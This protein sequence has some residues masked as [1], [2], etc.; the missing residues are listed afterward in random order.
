MRRVFPVLANQ[1]SSRPLFQTD[2]QSFLEV[3]RKAANN[4]GIKAV[5]YQMRPLRPVVGPY[6]GCQGHHVLPE[7]RTLGDNDK[8]Q[9]GT[10]ST[11]VSTTR[12]AFLRLRPQAYCLTC[13]HD[14]EGY[15]LAGKTCLFPPRLAQLSSQPLAEISGQPRIASTACLLGYWARHWLPFISI[16]DRWTF[17]QDRLHH[18]DIAGLF[19]QVPRGGNPIGSLRAL[20]EVASDMRV[21]AAFLFRGYAPLD[22]N[23][24]K[25][26]RKPDKQTT[27]E[28]HLCCFGSPAFSPCTVLLHGCAKER[29]GTLAVDHKF[30]CHGRHG[31]CSFRPGHKHLETRLASRMKSTRASTHGFSGLSISTLMTVG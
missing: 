16:V 2:Y 20:S 23:S 21:P 19:V 24:W 17:V 29:L 8:S 6:T 9:S 10:K 3:F 28:L 30:R 25:D 31:F 14:A 11:A 13:E 4:I 15:N 1:G 27:V 18:H 7:T 22:V 5:P 26:P 12:G